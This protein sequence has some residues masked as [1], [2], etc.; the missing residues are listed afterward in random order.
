[1]GVDGDDRRPRWKHP[2]FTPRPMSWMPSCCGAPAATRRRSGSCTTGTRTRWHRYHLRRCGDPHAAQDLTA[3]T[4]AQAW[5]A[6][7]RFTDRAGGSAGPWLFGIARN[8]LL[9]S[10]RARWLERAAC[11]RLGLRERLD[12]GPAR[13]VPGR[14]LAGRRGRAAG[15]PAGA[16]GRGPA[17]ARGRRPGL[18]GRRRGTGDHPAGGARPRLTRTARPAT[19]PRRR[20]CPMNDPAR[21]PAV[22][23]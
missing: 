22:P 13:A 5:L 23:G 17:P 12:R 1:M 20:R 16:P 10:V 3:E 14:G 18:R 15:R 2:P 11:E 7:T 19:A 4:F 9:R 6:R 8:V 21:G